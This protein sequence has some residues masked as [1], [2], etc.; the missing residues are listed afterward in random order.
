MGKLVVFLDSN[1]YKRCGHNFNSTPMRKLQELVDKNIIHLISTTVV[2]GEVNE[3]IDADVEAFLAAQKRLVQSAGGVQNV[4]EYCDF[5][6]EIDFDDIKQKVHQAFE[7][8]IAST[9]CEVLS[10]NGIDNDALL[11]DFFAKRPPFEKRTKKAAEFK[12][13]FISYTLKRYAET[14][15][16][17][18]YIVSS[19]DGFCNSFNRDNRF[20]IF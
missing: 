6:R 8:F 15:D 5:L 20:K 19:D 10:C 18:I 11:S 4:P 13:A 16:I 2:N 9:H 17:K 14:N 3:H 7:N 12:D 1:E